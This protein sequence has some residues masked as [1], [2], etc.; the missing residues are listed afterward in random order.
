MCQAVMEYDQGNYKRAFELLYPL[1]YRI[2]EVGGSDAQVKSTG[3][4]I[5]ITMTN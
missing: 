4:R 5:V 3:E 2:V 1:R